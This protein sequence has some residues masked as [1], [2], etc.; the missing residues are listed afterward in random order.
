MN[1]TKKFVRIT[2]VEFEEIHQKIEPLIG[3]KCTN[4]RKAISN[5]NRLAVT[6]FY[7]AS[8]DSFNN[9]S[10]VFKIAP[11]TIGKIIT[12]VCEAIYN[13]LKEDYLKTPSTVEEWYKIADGFWEKWNFMNYMGALDGKHMN[14]IKPDRSGSEYYNY[15]GHCSIVLMA[16]ADANHCFTYVN[17]GAKGSGSDGGIFN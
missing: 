10:I 16:L 12:D 6:L 4:M 1:F 17:I 9:L 14:I 7:L 11:C 8:G 5:R 15:K 13:I 2:F 3:K